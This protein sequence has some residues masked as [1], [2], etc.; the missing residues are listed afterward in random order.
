MTLHSPLALLLLL[1]LALLLASR[2]SRP[3]CALPFPAAADLPGL[4]V[5]VRQRVARLL[6]LLR[7]LAL[8]LAV[9]ALARPQLVNTET[10]LVSQGIDM[11]L[12]IDLSTSMLAVDR[13]PATAQRSR[14]ATAKE[15]AGAFIARRA[16]DRI[17]LV[18]FAARAYPAAPLTLDHGW[19]GSVLES[20]DVGR[21]EDGTAL[22][23]GLVAALNRLRNSPLDNRV[24]IVITDGRANAGVVAPRDAAAAAR[25]LGIRV[26]T[27]GI[28][29]KGAAVF[30]VADPLG[31][32]AWRQ[33]RAELDEA[34]LR[35]IAAAT[36]GRYFP[37]ASAA[38]LS[39]VF[40]EID[41]LEKA[42]IEQQT[43]RSTEE[44]FPPLVLVVMLIVMAECALRTLWL[45]TLP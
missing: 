22:G 43:S 19:L 40:R 38:D 5:T 36:G 14:L 3:E 31:G 15:V 12:A 7:T 26:H 28:G 21:I 1:P 39:A 25:A 20:L 10:T 6:P 8:V 24:A 32:V 29:G 45:R 44:L 17:G 13:D 35:E 41:T 27:V 16:S 34:T 18:A 2:R 42:T 33:V 30:P 37:A 9:I 23:D 11:V 4:P